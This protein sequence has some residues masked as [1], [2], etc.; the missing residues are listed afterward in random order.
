MA[1]RDL[2]GSFNNE[3]K[4]EI[5]NSR[6]QKIKDDMERVFSE[7]IEDNGYGELDTFCPESPLPAEEGTLVYD[8]F[9][10]MRRC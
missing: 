6:E 9:K 2:V 7:A 10:M 5:V 8:K 1:H 4:S 3:V